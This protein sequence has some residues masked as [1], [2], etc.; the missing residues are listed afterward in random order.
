MH[1]VESVMVNTIKLLRK[2]NG[3]A[4]NGK[5]N[6]HPNIFLFYLSNVGL[7]LSSR[8]QPVVCMYTCSVSVSINVHLRTQ[9]VVLYAIA[10][11]KPSFGLSGYTA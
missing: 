10:E 7:P 8:Q 11:S 6:M 5:K 3:I 9:L 1:S 4:K 2:E